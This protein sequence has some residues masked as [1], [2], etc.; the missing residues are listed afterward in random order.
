MRGALSR[1]PRYVWGEPENGEAV[2]AG[3]TL[4]TRGWFGSTLPRYIGAPGSYAPGEG[5]PP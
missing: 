2:G 1:R 5:V 3:G 4:Y